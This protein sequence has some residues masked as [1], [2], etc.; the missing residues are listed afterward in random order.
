[1]D[2]HSPSGKDRCISCRAWRDLVRL[3]SSVIS[4]KPMLNRILEFPVDCVDFVDVI[5]IY[6]S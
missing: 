2:M 1:M 3:S 6:Y 4:V 5:F